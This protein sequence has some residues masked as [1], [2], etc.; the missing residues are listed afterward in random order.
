MI[1]SDNFLQRQVLGHVGFQK[2]KP[3]AKNPQSLRTEDMQKQ[4]L[5]NEKTTQ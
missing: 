1:G 5:E 4:V 2:V 3:L